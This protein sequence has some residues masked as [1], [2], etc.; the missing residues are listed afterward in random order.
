MGSLQTDTCNRGLILS[1]VV[2]DDDDGVKIL[3][4]IEFGKDSNNFVDA[5]VDS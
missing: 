5:D 2:G 4:S 3:H 1:G